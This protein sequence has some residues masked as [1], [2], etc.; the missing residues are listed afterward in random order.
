MNRYRPIGP[1]GDV[2]FPKEKTGGEEEDIYKFDILA[3]TGKLLQCLRG[4]NETLPPFIL[5]KFKEELREWEKT[6]EL[7]DQVSGHYG[8][9]GDIRKRIRHAFFNAFMEWIKK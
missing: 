8:L 7:L 2:K 3:H 4:I 9:K 1:L 6:L 5:D